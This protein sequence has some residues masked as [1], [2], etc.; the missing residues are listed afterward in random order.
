MPKLWTETIATHRQEVRDAILQSAAD[1]V[2]EHGL[3]SVTMSQIAE[4]T[5]IGRATLYK[6]FPDVE[7]ILI[8][9]HERHV[10][11]HLE[12]LGALRDGDEPPLERL[13]AVLEAFAHIQHRRHE[14][15][16]RALLH[17]DQHASPTEKHLSELIEGLLR[18]CQQ[19]QMVRDDVPADQLASYCIHALAAA[20]SLRSEESV[21]TLVGLTL[22]GLQP[23]EITSVK[24]HRQSRLHRMAS[25]AERSSHG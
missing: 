17:R 9:W 24:T 16:L 13:V 21:Q 15:E 19:A 7:A 6:Y 2:S 18:E 14:N 4:T 23:S 8:V 22:A 10:S 20:A 3:R 11:R 12:Q 5:G 25:R 1:L